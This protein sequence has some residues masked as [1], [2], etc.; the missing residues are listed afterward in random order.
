MSRGTPQR[1][2]RIDPEL[3]TAAQLIAESEGTTLSAVIRD[4]LRSYVEGFAKR[5][6][7]ATRPRKLN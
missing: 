5:D 1:G 4:A 6:G 7:A 2:I 3:W